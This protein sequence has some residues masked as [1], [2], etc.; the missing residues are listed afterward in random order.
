MIDLWN[1]FVE[2]VFGGFHMAVGGMGGILLVILILGGVSLLTA[3]WY[4]G[5]FFAVMYMGYGPRIIPAVIFIALMVWFF[6]QLKGFI[7]RSGG[8]Y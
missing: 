8:N 3:M 1:L 5:I 6:L 4:D 2:N 7:D